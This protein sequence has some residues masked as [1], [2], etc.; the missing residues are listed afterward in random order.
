MDHY[1]AAIFTRML[2][3]PGPKVVPYPGGDAADEDAG[4]DLEEPPG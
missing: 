1:G 4:S 2:A 3:D